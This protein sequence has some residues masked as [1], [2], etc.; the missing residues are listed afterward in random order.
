MPCTSGLHF[1][2]FSRLVRVDLSISYA[3]S[4]QLRSWT[5]SASTI[6]INY[7]NNTVKLNQTVA[8]AASECDARPVL[9]DGRIGAQIGSLW[10][11]CSHLL[12]S[13]QQT[14]VRNLVQCRNLQDLSKILL[15]VAYSIMERPLIHDK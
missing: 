9:G 6:I 4:V 5:S 10:R 2:R 12:T 15:S 8:A 13:P 1:L 3:E 7:I 14:L 11:S